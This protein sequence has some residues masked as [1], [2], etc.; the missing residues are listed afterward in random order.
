[1]SP[2][3]LAWSGTAIDGRVVVLTPAGA[4]LACASLAEL[5]EHLRQRQDPW[6]GFT[7]CA[8]ALGTALHC[9]RHPE[10]GVDAVV[11]E[12]GRLLKGLPVEPVLAR[13]RACAHHH[14]DILGAREIG[15]RL[16]LEARR[17]Q[18]EQAEAVARTAEQVRAVV[19]P[20]RTLLLAWPGGAACDLGPGLLTGAVISSE[21]E[22]PRAEELLVCGPAELAA[23]A[24]ADFAAHGLAALA[25]DQAAASKRIAGAPLAAVLVRCVGGSGLAEAPA[26]A[27]AAEAARRRIPV[28]ALGVQREVPAQAPTLAALPLGCQSHVA[29]LPPA[30]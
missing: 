22:R 11:D 4:S 9:T 8:A 16:V 13:L 28:L 26:A 12:A 7:A 17:M 14:T 27:L 10:L 24:V 23:A 1:M 29:T 21:R 20:L 18:R 6:G 15:A 5:A 3:P 30:A 2:P 19:R 25:I